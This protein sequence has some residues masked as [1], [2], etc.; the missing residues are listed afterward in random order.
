MNYRPLRSPDIFVEDNA[1]YNQKGYELYA[2][3]FQEKMKE[4]FAQF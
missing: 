3:F 2:E 1:H 4:E